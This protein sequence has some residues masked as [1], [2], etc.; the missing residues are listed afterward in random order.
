MK[1]FL[2]CLVTVLLIAALIYIGV[3]SYIFFEKT[4]PHRSARSMYLS[5]M[6]D[7]NIAE[8]FDSRILEKKPRLDPIRYSCSEKY[9]KS[10]FVNADLNNCD[11]TIYSDTAGKYCQILSLGVNCFSIAVPEY[12]IEDHELFE[13]I[14]D[15]VKAP[16]NYTYLFENKRMKR[17]SENVFECQSGIHVRHAVNIV[18]FNKIREDGIFY[19][20]NEKD[21]RKVIYY[22]NGLTKIEIFVNSMYKYIVG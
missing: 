3:V 7:L 22:G 17:D 18:V 16:C 19:A 9:S 21:I 6:V 1:R 13:K 8:N 15:I 12:L 20:D 10:E 5:M 4:F 14:Q 2:L 11:F